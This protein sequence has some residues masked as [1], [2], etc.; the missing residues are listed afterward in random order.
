MTTQ[1]MAVNDVITL[2]DLKLLASG[3]SLCITIVA[4]IPTRVELSKRLK[5]AIKLE[6]GEFGVGVTLIN[7]LWSFAKLDSETEDSMDR[8]ASSTYRRRS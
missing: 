7:L 8:R 3:S 1:E 5:N 4:H 2:P 6:P